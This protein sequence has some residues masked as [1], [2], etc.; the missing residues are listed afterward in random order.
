MY[1]KA[2]VHFGEYCLQVARIGR[3]CPLWKKVYGS[4]SLRPGDSTTE[5]PKINSPPRVSL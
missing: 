4:K 3:F 2:H 5:D 1:N